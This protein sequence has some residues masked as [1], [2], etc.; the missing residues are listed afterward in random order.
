VPISCE[1]ACSETGGKDAAVTGTL[2]SVPP[3]GGS[4]RWLPVNA[5]SSRVFLGFRQRDEVRLVYL[6]LRDVLNRFGS[7][8]EG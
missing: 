6:T 2:G 4:H 3:R 7:R 5:A 8:G 1:L